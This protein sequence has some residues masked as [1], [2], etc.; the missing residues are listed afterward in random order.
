MLL[1][2][3]CRRARACP[4]LFKS[5]KGLHEGMSVRLVWPLPDVHEPDWDGPALDPGWEPEQ[6][7]PRWRWIPAA[8]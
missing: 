8:V 3:V 5:C 6:E 1:M 7:T 2:T 4:S